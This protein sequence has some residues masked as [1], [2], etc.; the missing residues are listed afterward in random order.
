M[1]GEMDDP[2]L[3]TF[4]MRFWEQFVLKHGSGEVREQ[5][6]WHLAEL[7]LRPMEHVHKL[8]W[9]YFYNDDGSIEVVGPTAG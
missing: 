3:V 5:L 1:H 6:L 9:D 7:G 2:Y 8:D 4:E